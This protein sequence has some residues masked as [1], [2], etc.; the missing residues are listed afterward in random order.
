MAYM[1]DIGL[2]SRLQSGRYRLKMDR[3]AAVILGG[4]QGSRLF[5]LTS[6]RPKPAVQFG[7]RYRLIDVPIS[8]ALNCNINKI[9]VLTQFLSTRLHQYLFQAYSNLNSNNSFIDILGVEQKRGSEGW[10]QGTADA[11]RQNIPYLEECPVDY[12]LILSGD[13]LYNMDYHDLLM[14]AYETNADTLVAS[15]AVDRNQASRMGLL[16][17]N[18]RNQIVNF[19]E[20]PKDPI[21]LDAM[22]SPKEMLERFQRSQGGAKEWLGSMGIYL[23]KKE[24]LL[25]LLKEDEREDFG[26]HLLPTCVEKGSAYVYPFDGYWEDIGTIESFFEA[27]LAL[28]RENPQFRCHIEENPI[29]SCPLRLPGPKIARAEIENSI[30]CGGSI[31]EAQSLSSSILGPRSIVKR[32]TKIERSYI[33]GGDYYTHPVRKN[34]QQI[35]EDCLIKNCIIDQNVRIG[36]G[37]VLTN[38]QNLQNFDSD[39]LFVRDGIIVIPKDVHLPEGF[40]F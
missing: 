1:S 3:V 10:Y 23:F 15:L 17:V 7:G 19:C 16:K 25:D 30:L 5:P 29:Y 11:V 22:K 6:M 12:F 8:N 13:Q 33:M 24:F 4:G 36:D 39:R 9:F 2:E 20:K 14:M 35:G 26:K 32:G 28:T 27:N 31:V 37:V 40:S 21:L 18:S 34:T 38:Q